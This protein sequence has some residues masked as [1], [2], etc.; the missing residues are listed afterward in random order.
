VDKLEE[1]LPGGVYHRAFGQPGGTTVAEWTDSNKA[2]EPLPSGVVTSSSI[3]IIQKVSTVKDAASSATPIA[4]SKAGR[5]PG[6][7][8]LDDYPKWTLSVLNMPTGV[9]A[10][11]RLVV[12]RTRKT[13]S[14]EDEAELCSVEIFP[15]NFVDISGIAPPSDA[16][17]AR[18]VGR[19]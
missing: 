3:A 10:N 18:I 11:L 13:L 6:K 16:E 4:I 7:T 19:G 1:F 12:H 8:S 14:Q 2:W 17:L 5:L 9:G 15:V